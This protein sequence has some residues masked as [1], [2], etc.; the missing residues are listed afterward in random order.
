MKKKCLQC[1]RV[2]RL[3]SFH[4][5]RTLPDGHK[6]YC[7]VCARSQSLRYYYAHKKARQAYTRTYQ[8]Q[9]PRRMRQIGEQ[10]RSRNQ[11]A[12]LQAKSQPCMDCGHSFIPFVM[13]LD[14]VRGRKLFALGAHGTRSLLAVQKEIAKC[15]AVCSNCHRLRTWKRMHRGKS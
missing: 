4:K 9:H 11:E 12:V 15:D 13:D 2:K 8:Q 14:H 6:I 10:S 7:K 3:T 5:D 1:N